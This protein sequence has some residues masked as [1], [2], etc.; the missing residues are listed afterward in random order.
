MAVIDLDLRVAQKIANPGDGGRQDPLGRGAS[1]VAVD[2]AFGA[3][4]P[5]PLPK[6]LELPHTHPQR[7]SPLSIGDGSLLGGSYEGLPPAP[8]A[9]HKFV[10]HGDDIITDELGV[11]F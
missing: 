1:P 6:P 3:P 4:L 5:E 11:T 8:F 2:Q 7:L 10:V 9:R